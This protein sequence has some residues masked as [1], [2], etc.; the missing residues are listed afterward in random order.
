MDRK[1]IIRAIQFVAKPTAKLATTAVNKVTDL[2]IPRTKEFMADWQEAWDN[3]ASSFKPTIIQPLAKPSKYR[4]T[5]YPEQEPSEE[6]KLEIAK[7]QTLEQE[8]KEIREEH[9]SSFGDVGI[10][11]ICT[12]P[13]IDGYCK[14]YKCWK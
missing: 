2:A 9:A 14:E 10:C 12:G 1:K 6:L 11:N 5:F 4:K 7:F 8:L 3:D 13:Y